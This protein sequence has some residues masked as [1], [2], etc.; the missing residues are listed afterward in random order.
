[1]QYSLPDFAVINNHNMCLSANEDFSVY[2]EGQVNQYW[3]DFHKQQSARKTAH[4]MPLQEK[5]QHLHSLL[6]TKSPITTGLCG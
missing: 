3:N 1:M 5:L 6:D 2:T 4:H